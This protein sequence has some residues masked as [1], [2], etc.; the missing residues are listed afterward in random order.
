MSLRLMATVLTLLLCSGSS[1]AQ[2]ANPST[3]HF[4][5]LTPAL[6]DVQAARSYAQSVG[7]HLVTIEDAAE[8]AWLEATFPGNH[9]IGLS[10]SMLEG[11][12]V[13]DGGQPLGY[14]N[15]GAGQPDNVSPFCGERGLRLDGRRR[16]V[17]R[18]AQLSLDAAASR[19][20]RVSQRGYRD[21]PG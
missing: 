9:W 10:D 15:W 6:G 2:Q 18:L 11:S 19:H 16:V 7:G 14:T 20:R 21:R 12:F 13:W 1:G 5:E 8:Q 17:R 4:Y 3:G